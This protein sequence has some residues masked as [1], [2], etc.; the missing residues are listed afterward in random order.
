VAQRKKET[1]PEYTAEPG[2][3]Y[4]FHLD[5][6]I[7]SKKNRVRFG[8]NGTYHDKTFTNWHKLAVLQMEPQRL[9]GWFSHTKLVRISFT[10]ESR[11]IKD[12]TNAAESVMDLLVDVGILKDDNFQVVPHLELNGVYTKGVSKTLVEIGI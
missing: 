9:S 4:S 12:L 2:I 8:K 10:F 11:R 5:G 3:F 6:N 1:R 7:P